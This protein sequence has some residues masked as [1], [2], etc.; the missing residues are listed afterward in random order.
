MEGN[1]TGKTAL[2]FVTIFTKTSCVFYL[3]IGIFKISKERHSI[4]DLFSGVSFYDPYTFQLFNLI[5]CSV[6]IIIYAV[7]FNL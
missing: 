3:N 2:W 6:P 7:K 5:Y 4:F 1:H